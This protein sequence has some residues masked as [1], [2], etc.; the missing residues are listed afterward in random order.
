MKKRKGKAP[1]TKKEEGIDIAAWTDDGVFTACECRYISKD[2]SRKIISTLSR[3]ASL[4]SG[5]K[6]TS[7]IL[8]TKGRTELRRDDYPSCSFYSLGDV[9]SL[10]S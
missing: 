10:L 5:G 8:F 6:R 4:I 2:I 9:L 7:F 3:R 1:V